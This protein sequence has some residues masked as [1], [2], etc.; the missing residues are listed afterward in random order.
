MLGGVQFHVVAVVL[1]VQLPVT[2]VGDVVAARVLGGGHDRPHLLG[3]GLGGQ[4][5]VD[6]GCHLLLSRAASVLV[7]SRP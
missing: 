3:G 4:G 2:G 6:G 7:E 5:L 1:R